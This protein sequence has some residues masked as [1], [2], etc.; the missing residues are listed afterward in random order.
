MFWFSRV[1]RICES[2]EKH[3]GVI[4]NTGRGLDKR[5]IQFKLFI[6]RWA[7]LSTL[8]TLCSDGFPLPR[9]LHRCF[10]G[11]YRG[12]TTSDHQLHHH[13]GH[14]HLHHGHHLHHLQM[15]HHHDWHHEGHK[16]CNYTFTSL[17][18]LWDCKAS[19]LLGQNA[20]LNY[21]FSLRKLILFVWEVFLE[22]G[23]QGATQ[24]LPRRGKTDRWNLIKKRGLS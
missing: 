21:C 13:H 4:L 18:G 20:K 9:Y 17:G 23:R 16:G 8:S 1:L 19:Y 24:E 14:H 22:L 6:F 5:S 7:A 3:S 11:I 2:L 10:Q 15:P 12:R